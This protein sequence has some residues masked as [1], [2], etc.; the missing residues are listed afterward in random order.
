M[1][2]FISGWFGFVVGFNYFFS[3]FNSP[4]Q[5]F[6]LNCIHPPE[7][8]PTAFN[9]RKLN[10]MEREFRDEKREAARRGGD[11]DGAG[12]FL[13]SEQD[14]S[15]DARADEAG[16]FQDD[17]NLHPEDEATDEPVP[18]GLEIGMFGFRDLD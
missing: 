16:I 5:D 4:R 15:W 18:E 8:T 14:E 6:F 10:C 13:L 2:W 3:F 17:D 9:P 12:S 1:V 11:Y 7:E